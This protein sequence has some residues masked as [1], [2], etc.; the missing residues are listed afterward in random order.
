M[1]SDKSKVI[2]IVLVFVAVSLLVFGIPGRRTPPGWWAWK[3]VIAGVLTVVALLAFARVNR[4]H[5]I[6]RK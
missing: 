5:S 1:K 6:D 4:D 2:G 3:L